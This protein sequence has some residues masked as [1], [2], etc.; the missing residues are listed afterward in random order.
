MPSVK[1]VYIPAH[2]SDPMEQWE[3]AYTQ[4]N[5][6]ECLL[7]KV[8]VRNERRRGE[9]RICVFACGLPATL[10]LSQPSSPLPFSLQDHFAKSKPSVRT[11][12]QL[13][14]QRAALLA[15]VPEEARAN[16]PESVLAAAA[17]GGLGMVENVALLTNAPAHGFVGINL[18]C[19]DEA[20]A[21]GAP[22][23]PRACEI[24]SVCGKPL[25][26]KGD[27]FLARVMD[28]DAEFERQDFLLSEVSSSAPWVKAA[29]DQAAA[30]AKRGSAEAIMRQ[31]GAGSGVRGGS[32]GGGGGGGTAGGLGKGA[33]PAAALPPPPPPPPLTPAA[34]ARAEGNTR[35]AAQDFEAAV[36]LYTRAADLAGEGEGDPAERAAALNNRAAARLRTGDWAGAAADAGVVLELEPGNVKALLRRGAGKEGL[37]EVEGAAADFRAAAAAEPGNAQATAGL[38]RLAKQ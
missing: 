6:V 26:V 13:A 33:A 31:M 21:L 29:A 27:A 12:G 15:H 25:Q 17:A 20:G 2:P 10:P 19:D 35:F 1:F 16:L 9:E 18:Y 7:D 5:E 22:L 36:V 3:V 30:R 14:A 8:K 24:A 28:S 38:A 34:A 32:G 4:A 23:N 11:P 37:G